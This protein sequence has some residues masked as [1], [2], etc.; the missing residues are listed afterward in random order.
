MKM[1]VTQTMKRNSL[2]TITLAACLL[3]L[4]AGS[5]NSAVGSFYH[6][7]ARGRLDHPRKSQGGDSP[8][9]HPARRLRHDLY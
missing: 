9:Q 8:R 3:A 7:T 2:K 6:P 4:G 1:A 5:G